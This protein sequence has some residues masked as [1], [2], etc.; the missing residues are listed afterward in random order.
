MNREQLAAG[1]DRD[2]NTYPQLMMAI[3]FSAFIHIL[4][5]IAVPLLGW[6]MPSKR[7][8]LPGYQV[9]L[10]TLSP[11]PSSTLPPGPP[12]PPK[13]EAPE[14]EP[15]PE[16]M[17]KKAPM[18]EK[19]AKAEPE[20]AKEKAAPAGKKFASKTEDKPKKEM[21]EEPPKKTRPVE[22]ASIPPSTV[23]PRYPGGGGGGG[24][25]QTE[26]APFPYL[27]YTRTIEMK[28]N[29]NWV[30]HGIILAGKKGDPVVKFKILRDGSVAGV[31]LEKSSGNSALDESALQA[32][33]KGAP[34]GPLP[35]DYPTDSLTVHFS[36]DY[37][38]RQ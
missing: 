2:I 11:K 29:Q 17:V 30:T 3:G 7:L 4:I 36:F 32:I 21:A 22:T 25:A 23:T 24:G 26:G 15:A 14:P 19:A 33:I 10:V 35:A 18:V 5:I 16:P 9:N 27:W 1:R 37:E 28:V 6:L 12:G 34:F 31:T 20:V 38:Q 13:E 8:I